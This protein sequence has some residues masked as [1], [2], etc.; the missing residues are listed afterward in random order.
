[1]LVKQ[2]KI[3]A[4]SIH[5]NPEYQGIKTEFYPWSYTGFVFTT[6]PNIRGLRH[7]HTDIKHYFL[8]IHDNPEYQGIKTN[9]GALGAI[10]QSIHDNPEYQGIKTGVQGLFGHHCRIHDNPEYQGIKTSLLDKAARRE[11]SRQHRISGD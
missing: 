4:N 10:V 11:Y 9:L 7:P 1:M 2:R 5:D 6:T 3:S 8:C